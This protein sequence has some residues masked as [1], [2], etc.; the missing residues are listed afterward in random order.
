MRPL[1]LAR[2]IESTGCSAVSS[3]GACWCVQ[4]PRRE[5]LVVI[6]HLSLAAPVA[7]STECLVYSICVLQRRWQESMVLLCTVGWPPAIYFLRRAVPSWHHILKLKKNTIHF[8]FRIFLCWLA[9][10]RDI[11]GGHRFFVAMWIIIMVE[12]KLLFEESFSFFLCLGCPCYRLS[13]S[14]FV[15][16]VFSS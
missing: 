7:R 10:D 11:L 13:R 8:A 2:V 14:Q 4:N 3:V 1:P 6:N 16:K 12:R 5:P 15:G 9:D